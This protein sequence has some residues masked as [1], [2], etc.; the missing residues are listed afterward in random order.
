MSYKSVI[1]IG[2]SGHGYAVVDVVLENK[3]NLL[4]YTE[5]NEL[6]DNPFNLTY[7]GFEMDN[8]FFYS[9]NDQTEY[10]IGIG[11]NYSREK[12][13]NYLI[14]SKKQIPLLISKLAVISDSVKMGKGVF[15]NK[16]AIINA[17]VTVGENSLINTGCIIEHECKIGNSVHIA[18]GSVLA[19]NVSIGDRSFIG[20]N[21]VIKQGVIIGKDVIV[22]AGSVVLQNIPDQKIVVGNPSRFI[23]NV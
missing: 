7:K 13:F 10:I 22:G 9:M 16:C 5:K 21:S 4:G 17:L 8:D 14:K 2:Y 23:K 15:V 11:D 1:L 20:A 6:K 19:G 12:A 3:W 18:S